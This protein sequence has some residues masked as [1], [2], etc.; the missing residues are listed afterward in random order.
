MNN[1]T[2]TTEEKLTE[3]L[4]Q[5]EI[6]HKTKSSEFQES[7]TKE[8]LREVDAISFEIV[9]LKIRIRYEVESRER[10]WKEFEEKLSRDEFI[11]FWE[12]RLREEVLLR[13]LPESEKMESSLKAYR[14]RA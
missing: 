4:T 14:R 11:V 9:D 8:A 3:Q 5:L 1:E 10:Y 7:L 13:E 12:D 6:K 2:Q